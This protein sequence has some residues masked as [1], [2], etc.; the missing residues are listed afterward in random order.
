V[1]QVEEELVAALLQVALV[2]ADVFLFITK[3][4]KWQHMQ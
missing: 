3:E 4:I 2:V 1:V